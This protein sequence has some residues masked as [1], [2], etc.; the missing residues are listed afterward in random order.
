M[1]TPA[2]EG[3]IPARLIVCLGLAQI[4]AWGTMHYLVSVF[5]PAMQAELGWS[6]GFVYGGFSCALAVMGLASVRVG[7]W[8]DA[9]G[10]RA[11][12]MT[13]CG[14]GAAGCVVLAA[15][16]HGF[17]YYLGWVLLGLGMRLA[18]YDAAFAALAHLGGSGSRQAMSQVTLFG[19]LSSTLFWPLGQW[20]DHAWGWRAALLAYALLLAASSLLH[21]AL[22]R[23]RRAAAAGTGR[24]VADPPPAAA[25][26]DVML[27]GC[28]ATLVLF[29]QTGMSAHLPGILR[30]LGW[31]PAAAVTLSTLFGIGQVAGRVGIALAGNRI[32]VLAVNLIPCAL[33]CLCFAAAL[34]AG[35]S[36]PG[37]AAFTLLYGAGNGM[38]TIMR[39]AIPLVLFD[40]RQYGRIVGGVLRPAFMLCATA[41]VAFAL[42]IDSLGYPGMLAVTLVLAGILLAAALV[43]HHRHRPKEIQP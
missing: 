30:G 11:A 8:I 15:A 6:P 12:M 18:L 33:L 25:R 26:M 22:P 24:A 42:A 1:D 36:L 17:V 37:A 40:T 31:A 10:G 34:A 41:P 21:L 23:G 20:M 39:G 43:L 7:R 3:A 35:A 16:H 4:V 2:G 32:G 28:I 13:G 38:A 5:G 19:G 29:L 27:Y 14:L 9:R